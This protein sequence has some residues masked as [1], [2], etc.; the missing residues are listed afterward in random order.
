MEE[1]TFAATRPKKVVLQ[2]TLI[3][4]VAQSTT[5]TIL[6]HAIYLIHTSNILMD[7]PPLE[8]LAKRISALCLA[9][10]MKALTQNN[11]IAENPPMRTHT[12]CIGMSP[13]LTIRPSRLRLELTI[14]VSVAL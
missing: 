1:G 13:M 11:L 5:T 10:L 4:W 14:F 2:D 8:V 9:A 3:S 12:T 6:F 7:F